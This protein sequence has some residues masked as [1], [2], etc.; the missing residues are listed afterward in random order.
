MKRIL[1]ALD[2]DPCALKVAEEGYLMAKAMNAEVILLHV[3]SNAI[4]YASTEFSPIKYSQTLGLDDLSLSQIKIKVDGL[5]DEAQKFLDKSKHHLG[6]ETIQ[7]LVEKGDFAESIIKS[8]KKL[9][10]DTI[11]LGSN[12]RK[13]LEKIVIGSVTE[14]VLYNTSIPLYIIPVKNTTD[15]PQN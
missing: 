3:L 9:H 2:Y 4:N 13:W 10:A 8:A 7:T 5:K 12:S 11:V 15:K 14:K 6:D 1:I